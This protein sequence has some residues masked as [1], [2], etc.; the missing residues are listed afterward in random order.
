MSITRKEVE[1]IARLSR[2]ALGEDEM[3]ALRADLASI[4]DHMRELEEEP[5]DGV[6]PM[7]GA[8]EQIAPMRD[9]TPGAIPLT[10]G[11]ADLAP[12][13]EEGF[14]VVPRLAA[15]DADAQGGGEGAG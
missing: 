13:W 6:A 8:L 5:L 11:P 3:E 12:A 14:F 2:L 1:Q 9:D 10:R 4:L 7:E 15:L